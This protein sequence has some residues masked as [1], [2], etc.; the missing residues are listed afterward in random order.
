MEFQIENPL[1]SP[2]YD[3]RD[4]YQGVYGYQDQEYDWGTYL[5]E[6]LWYWDS[7]PLGNRLPVQKSNTKDVPEHEDLG[8]KP[9]QYASG[10]NLMENMQSEPLMDQV[11][12]KKSSDHQDQ[13]YDW[14]TYL[15]ERLWFRE[16]GP[17]TNQ[18]PIQKPN[19]ADDSEYED[20]ENESIPNAWSTNLMDFLPSWQSKPHRDQPPPKESSDQGVS[21]FQVLDY[22][23]GWMAYLRNNILAWRS[24]TLHKPPHEVEGYR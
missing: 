11:P 5:K 14:G 1:S 8:N 19:T 20:L 13:D 15:K 10:T 18:I 17:L 7:A 3:Y 22:Q 9:M 4:E 2:Q 24:E 16:S 6:R 23:G 12:P 21:E